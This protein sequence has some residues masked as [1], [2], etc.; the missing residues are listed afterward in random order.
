ML[1]HRSRKNLKKKLYMNVMHFFPV[2]LMPF[3][4]SFD[5]GFCSILMARRCCS[6][7]NFEPHYEQDPQSH[8]T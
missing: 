1:T 3:S 2:I 8:S 6:D 4:E 5:D 7:D